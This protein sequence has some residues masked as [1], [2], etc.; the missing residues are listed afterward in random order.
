MKS[1]AIFASG[2]GSNAQKIMQHFHNHPS[3]KVALVVSNKHA[4]GVLDIAHAYGVDTFVIDAK[5]IKNTH[6]LLEKIKSKHIDY[7][8]LAGFLVLVPKYLIDAYTNK[9]INIHPALLP[10]YGGKGMYGHFVHEAVK[11]A[12]EQESGITIHFANEHYDEGDYI[13]Q[14]KCAITPQDTPEDI[15]LKV[16]ALEHLHFAPVLE[17]LICFAAS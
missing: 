11:A 13:F 8:V 9:I 17:K 5:Q 6:I 15:A 1:I 12:G 10:Q 14:A 2:G 3:I 7:I 4:A 16:L